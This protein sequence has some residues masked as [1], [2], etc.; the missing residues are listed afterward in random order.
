MSKSTNLFAHT[1]ISTLI[2]FELPGLTASVITA[3][4]IQ[5]SPKA[6][7]LK[8]EIFWNPVLI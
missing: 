1:D 4:C 2:I 3:Y 7:H 5:V 8:T 6:S